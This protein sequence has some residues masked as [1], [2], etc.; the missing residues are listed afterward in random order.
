MRETKTIGINHS[1]Y[2]ELRNFAG[3]NIE[4]Y[5]FVQSYDL[6]RIVNHI[7]FKLKNRIKVELHN[8][9][10][11][12]PDS[13]NGYHFFNSVSF[14]S[15]PW[16]ST[17]ETFLPRWGYRGSRL[18]RIG[19]EQITKAPCH[20]IIAISEETSRIMREMVNK[21]YPD[22]YKDIINKL[23]II[24]PAQK[25][26]IE[27]RTRKPGDVIN[28]V[29]VGGDFF[30]KGG[31]SLARAF[32]RLIN[33][34][35]PIHLT[36]V[37][38]L[39]TGDYITHATD[40]EKKQVLH[41]IHSHPEHITHYPYLKNNQVLSLL[42]K[43]DVA[44]LPTLMDTYGYSVLESQAC[45][46]PVI[47]TDIRALPEINSGTT[48]WMIPTRELGDPRESDNMR[49]IETQIEQQL[50]SIVT[51]IV[52]DPDQIITKGNASI[53]RIKK[54]HNPEKIATKLQTIYDQF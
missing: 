31:A 4:N 15:K 7:Y 23:M 14:G 52:N 54:F 53:E 38:K 41:W 39:N 24:H 3:L 33:D 19:M 21:F 20:G 42:Q 13:V 40:E 46:C 17:F 10:I 32:D 37:S 49:Q 30:C 47:T 48:G 50:A 36:I 9:H 12:L 11:P 1:G 45:G 2:P 35:Y 26:I 28:F 27:T 29:F 43:M 22:L 16:V 8:A 18:H 51:D 6:L 44:L 25:V 5:E 34:G